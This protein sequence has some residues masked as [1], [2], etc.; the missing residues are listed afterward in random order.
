MIRLVY[1]EWTII[2]G[3]QNASQ[4]LKRLMDAQTWVAHNVVINGVGF[5][6]Q[7]G[8]SAYISSYLFLVSL[9]I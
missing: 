8:K 7:K 3:A 5:A 2:I 1:S 4:Y 9:S 6:D